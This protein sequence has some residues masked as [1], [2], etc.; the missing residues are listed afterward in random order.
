MCLIRCI[1]ISTHFKLH[2]RLVANEMKTVEEMTEKTT[3]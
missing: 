3:F 2:L 1:R